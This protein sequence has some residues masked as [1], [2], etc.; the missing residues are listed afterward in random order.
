M[1][2]ATK[3]ASEK[4]PKEWIDLTIG[5]PYVITEA[6]EAALEERYKKLLDCSDIPMLGYVPPEG[7][8][9]LLDVLR[10]RYTGKMIVGAG[11]TQLL[12]AAMY[13]LKKIGRERICM[14]TPWWILTP[15]IIDASGL[16]W[17][18]IENS[19]NYKPDC[20]L[21]TSPNNPD[22]K[23]LSQKELKN[24][25]NWAAKDKIPLVHDASY[26][27]PVYVDYPHTMVCGDVQIYSLSKMYGLSGLRI[28]FARVHNDEMYEHMRAYMEINSMGVSRLS[29]HVVTKLLKLFDEDEEAERRFV[30]FA[31]ERLA[32]NRRMFTQEVNQ[33]VIDCSKAKDQK[34]MF[35]WA[36]VG[37]KYDPNKT[38]CKI[39]DGTMFGKP[40]YLRINLALPEDE[41]KRAIANLNASIN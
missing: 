34:G 2:I 15:E 9:E 28:G 17:C 11:A 35:L 8:E 14:P 26:F 25:H 24:I 3:L 12:G 32:S 27:S 37:I 29:Q 1:S 5:E 10:K 33:D 19:D 39:I 4:L 16:Q 30:E 20:F 6:L 36:R 38:K 40:G 23:T 22:G 41:L 7:T 18:T 21:L 13:A 31:R